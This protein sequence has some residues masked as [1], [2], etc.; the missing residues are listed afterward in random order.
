MSTVDLYQL[1]IHY[2]S[3]VTFGAKLIHQTTFMSKYLPTLRQLNLDVASTLSSKTSFGLAAE[4]VPVPIG[5]SGQ[6]VSKSSGGSVYLKVGTF[7]SDA[8]SFALLFYFFLH[9]QT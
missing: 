3:K 2:V 4:D 7:L 1:M 9:Y 8:I 5:S 6:S